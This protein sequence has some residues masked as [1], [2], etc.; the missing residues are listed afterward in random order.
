MAS[1][2]TKGFGQELSICC[3]LYELAAVHSGA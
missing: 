1:A 2:L 3:Q